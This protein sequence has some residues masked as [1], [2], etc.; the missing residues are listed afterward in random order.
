VRDGTV[1]QHFD[2][3]SLNVMLRVP[4]VFVDVGLLEQL[5]RVEKQK[6]VSED[7]K[8]EHRRQNF[9]D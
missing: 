7:A 2:G 9:T 4:R 5:R 3:V 8:R 1:Y 6:R